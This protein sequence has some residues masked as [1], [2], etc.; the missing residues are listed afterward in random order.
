[1]L[2]HVELAAL[3]ADLIEVVT[4]HAQRIAMEDGADERTDVL[5]ALVAVVAGAR[6]VLGPLALLV[7]EMA[8][9]DGAT[10]RELGRASGVSEQAAHK[11]LNHGRAGSMERYDYR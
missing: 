5:L 10:Y 4:A 7:D 2:T 11:R 3:R 1:M 8:R 9:E 6:E